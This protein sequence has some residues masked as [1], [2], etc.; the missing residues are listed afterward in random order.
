MVGEALAW[1][2]WV[3]VVVGPAAAEGAPVVVAAE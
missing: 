2:S 3:V 1:S